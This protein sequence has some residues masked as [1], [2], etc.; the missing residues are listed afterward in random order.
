MLVVAMSDHDQYLG[1]GTPYPNN[2]INPDAEVN[3]LQATM[4]AIDST[5]ANTRRRTSLCKARA[6][7]P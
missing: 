3:G 1:M 2:R 5:A 6:L 7:G 4:A